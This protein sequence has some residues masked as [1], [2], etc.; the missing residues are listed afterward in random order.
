MIKNYNGRKL[1]ISSSHRKSLLR[2][3]AIELFRYEKIKT[4]LPKAKELASYFEKLIT[5]SKQTNLSTTR[6]IKCEINDKIIAKKIFDI[7]SKRYQGRKG[8]YTKI[9]KTGV[10]RGDNSNVVI[11]KLI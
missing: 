4:T 7:F 9:I 6:A 10:R 8:G 5:K 11:I 3:L 1:G 2:N